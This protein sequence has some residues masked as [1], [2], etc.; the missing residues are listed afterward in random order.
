MNTVIVWAETLIVESMITKYDGYYQKII[1]K[2]IQMFSRVFA[3]SEQ[4]D[5]KVGLP[6]N[7]V[8]SELTQ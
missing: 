8:R 4:Q 6:P 2:K 7:N 1:P 3:K 5:D